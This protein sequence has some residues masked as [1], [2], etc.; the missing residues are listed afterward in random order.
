MNIKEASKKD[1]KKIA[2]IIINEYGK[3]PYFEKWTESGAIKTLDYFSKVG[4]IY[5]YLFKKIIVGTIIVREEYYNYGPNLIIEE[6]VVDRKFQ[7]KG[8]GK[9]LVY[10]VE[11]YCR[12]NKIKK[13]ILYANNK[14]SAY[15]F[16]SNRGFIH[17][18]HMSYFSKKLKG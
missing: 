2:N 8:V 12:K 16:Y 15:G 11:E 1:F 17:H 18:K 9:E 6:L 7:G 5:I 3:K 10:F 13:I 14:A 4:K